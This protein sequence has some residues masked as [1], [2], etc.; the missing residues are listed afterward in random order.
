MA[1]SKIKLPRLP[2]KRSIIKQQAVRHLIHSAV[3]CAGE[4]P[5]AIQLSVQSADEL[6]AGR[7]DIRSFFFLN[8]QFLLNDEVA[9][10]LGHDPAT[11]L[12]AY[13]KQTDEATAKLIK[14]VA[15]MGC[16]SN[17]GRTFG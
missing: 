1:K 13:A 17:N 11:L 15:G 7:D 4:D 14:S 6:L 2:P 9:K 12:S 3:C 8:R 10:R 16:C 5:F